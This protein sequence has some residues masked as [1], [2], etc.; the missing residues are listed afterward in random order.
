MVARFLGS[1]MMHINIERDVR[2]SIDMMKFCVNHYDQFTNVTA[3]FSIALIWAIISL[4]IE[5]NVMVILSTMPDII[6]VIM[7]YVSLAAISKIP[8]F[9]FNSLTEHKCLKIGGK[10][11]S[12][13]KFRN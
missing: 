8:R 12:K 10:L 4:V 5:F 3:A 9:Y 2:C 11:I 6:G 13:N 1:L 7:K